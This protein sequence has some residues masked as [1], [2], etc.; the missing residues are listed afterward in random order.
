MA[1]VPM[2]PLCR[3]LRC[4]TC[5]GKGPV[6]IRSSWIGKDEHEEALR[7]ARARAAKV[8]TIKPREPK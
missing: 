4:P 2:L 8:R 1:D 3:R 7:L 5:G 6:D